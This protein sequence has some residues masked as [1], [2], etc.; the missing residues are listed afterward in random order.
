MTQEEMNNRL[1]AMREELTNIVNALLV[2]KPL[3]KETLGRH[4]RVM[5]ETIRAGGAMNELK[6]RIERLYK[7]ASQD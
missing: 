2:E 3:T 5:D 1:D 7:S 4:S 6:K